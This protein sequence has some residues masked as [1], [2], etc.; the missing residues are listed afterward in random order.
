MGSG[1]DV[2]AVGRS[3]IDLYANEIG[4]PFTEVKTFS[5]YVGGSPTNIIVGARRLGLRAAL[6]TAVG[7]DLVGDFVLDFLAREGVEAAFSPRKP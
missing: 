6:L 7:E 2:L 3:S 5:A 1:Y 4:A